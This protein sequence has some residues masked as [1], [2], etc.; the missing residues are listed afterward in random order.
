[1]AAEYQM[2]IGGEWTGGSG[3]ERLDSVN[4]YTQEVWA[5]LPQAGDADVARAIEIAHDTYVS[6]WR[7]VNGRDRALMLNRLADLVEQNGPDL[8]RIDTTDN[9]K[10]IRETGSQMKFAARNY[11]YFAGLA[12]KLQGNTIPLDNG[13][14]LDYTIVEPLGV[15]VL[16]T[17]WNSPLP[18]LANKL[19]PALAAGNTVVIKPSEHASI[20]TLAFGR[21]IAEAGFPDGVVNI[22]TGDGRIGPALT[23]HKRVKKISFT[24]G[25]PTARRILEAAA[26]RLVP[27]T[28]E[29]GGKSPNIIFEDADLKAAVNGAVAGIFG[30]SGQTCIAGSRLL[31]QSSIYDEVCDRVLEKVRGIRLGNP[32][33][34]AT[35]MGPVANR[36][37]FDRILSLIAQAENEGA[38]LALGG[39]QATGPGLERGFFI[40]P[41][42][43]KDVEPSLT[44]A[45]DEVFGPVLCILRFEDEADAVRI[46]NDSDYGLAAGVWT[47]DVRR[48][49]RMAREIEA[50]LVWVNTYRASYVGAP[51]GGTKLSGHGRERSWH[52]L[53]EYTQVKNVMLDLS[54][55]D[56]DPFAMKL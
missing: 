25:L 41:T 52:T 51:F 49:H 45:R 27:V 46:A 43:L 40:E 21:L 53:M 15:A 18:L 54:G 3:S 6:V 20:S 2:L 39:R 48:A 38:K 8:A 28:T 22:V 14:M 23:T 36:A 12:D 24:G 9:G 19:A 47:N 4:P 33:D 11:R 34:P 29:L 5:T 7:G 44:I 30:A 37:Q 13:E 16:I 1:M 56:R 50:G 55:E 32:L 31:V 10:V 42:V 35:E 26:R 17:A